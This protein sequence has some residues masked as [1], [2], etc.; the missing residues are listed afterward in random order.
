MNT[1]QKLAYIVLGGV[2]VAAGMIISPLNAQKEKF[3]EIECT[4]LTVADDDGTPKII[5]VA[6]DYYDAL[7][8]EAAAILIHAAD[9]Y[10]TVSVQSTHKE[11]KRLR[12][13][14]LAVF[15][16][17]V[18]A[19]IGGINGDSSVLISS[20]EHG[21]RVDI[22]NNE[23]KK[24]G[25]FGVNSDGGYV[26]LIGPAEKTQ[27]RLFIDKYGGVLEVHGNGDSKGGAVMGI[28]EKGNGAMSTYDKNGYRQ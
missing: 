3:G 25:L 8:D 2:L 14:R 4:K 11:G 20:D 18:G 27:A 16:R 22:Q 17:S 10:R 5:L 15:G 12:Y 26:D 24:V 19:T 7:T 9:F 6:G 23:G 1:K 28:N 13:A 21:G